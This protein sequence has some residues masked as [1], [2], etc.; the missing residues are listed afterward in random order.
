MT[1]SNLSWERVDRL[2]SLRPDDTFGLI[3]G[4]VDSLH[5][6]LRMLSYQPAGPVD[7]SS[8]S[9]D[10]ILRRVRVLRD[11]AE[12]HG[13][14]VTMCQCDEVLERAGDVQQQ[15]AP[16]GGLW[17]LVIEGDVEP[18]VD[19]PYRT[20]E[21]R[22]N[23][24]RVHRSTFGDGDGLYRLD[25]GDVASVSNFTGDELEPDDGDD[26]HLTIAYGPT[27]GTRWCYATDGAATDDPAFATCTDC[28]DRY[29]EHAS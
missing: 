28:L 10:E 12:R 7:P 18:S 13:D 24:A 3:R 17:L 2:L 20:E 25:V 15:L 21:A 23:A 9:D 8:Q 26:L 6:A 27:A 22:T 5:A 4:R 16:L 19:G 29:R 14:A 1:A 11:T